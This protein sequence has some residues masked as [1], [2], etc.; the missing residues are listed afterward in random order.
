MN[1]ETFYSK[2][3]ISE[4][5]DRY[6][7]LVNRVCYLDYPNLNGKVLESGTIDIYRSSLIDMPLLAKYKV[8]NGE[9]TFGGHEAFITA[10]GEVVYGTEAIGTHVDT[11]VA[12]D[13]MT[14]NNEKKLVPCLFAVS[15]VWKRNSNTISTIKKLYR[16]NRLYSSW[17]LL[18]YKTEQNEDG[19][20]TIKQYAF[21]GNCLLGTEFPAYGV[22]AGVISV[23]SAQEIAELEESVKKDKE[24]SKE[25]NIM[26]LEEAMA[27]IMELN[28]ANTTLSVEKSQLENKVETLVA[29]KEAVEKEKTELSEQVISLSEINKEVTASKEALEVEKETINSELSQLKEE[30]AEIEKEKELSEMKVI[31]SKVFSEEEIKNDTELS[32]IFESGNKDALVKYIGQKAI[33]NSTKTNTSTE[34]SSTNLYSTK[35]NTQE[36][37]EKANDS[38]VGLFS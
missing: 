13:Y 31:A 36:N 19:T 8:I 24:L 12:N 27:K 2:I 38:F 35:D 1:K 32:S 25:G 9:E 20:E 22:D 3:E 23:A 30:K 5:N 26:T 16:E 10:D 21:L 4:E 29:E 33:E 15:R 7:T 14:I 6:L 11:Y 18:K 34:T 17:E 37:K 28:T